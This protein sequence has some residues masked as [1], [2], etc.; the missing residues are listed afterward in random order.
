MEEE[1]ER[2]DVYREEAEVLCRHDD[3]PD[4]PGTA[5]LSGE[6]NKPNIMRTD[7][8]RKRSQ[9]LESI[10]VSSFPQIFIEH[11]QIQVTER[12]YRQKTEGK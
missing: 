9:N 11:V 6:M 8:L 10:M 7:R 1:G 2:G 4:D 12:T 5:A 3:D